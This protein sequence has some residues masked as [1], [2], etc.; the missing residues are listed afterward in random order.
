MRLRLACTL[1][2]ALTPH[3]SPAQ[4]PDTSTIDY[5]ARARADSSR[6]PYTKADI[7]F[8]QGMIHHH[9]QAIEMSGMASTHA[10]SPSVLTL[11]ARIINAQKD[12]IALMSTWLRDRHQAVPVLTSGPTNM[13]MPGMEHEMPMPMPSTG[14]DMPMP[15]MLSP[16]Q[17]KALDEARGSD[18]DRKFLEG[19]IQHHRG[20]VAMVD[21]L[22]N[23]YGA[24]QDLLIQKLSQDIQV[25][26]RTE[27]A[28]MQ[29]MLAALVFGV[30]L[31]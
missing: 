15:G 11:S 27:I 17:M 10:A 13:K 2:I 19:M 7:D 25:D 8:V 29:K 16:A 21:N 18:F 5:S 3:L 9:A 26:Q 4:R 14:H 28:R 12:E 23:T 20:A 30:S 24:N 31:P 6:Y 1:A 22:M